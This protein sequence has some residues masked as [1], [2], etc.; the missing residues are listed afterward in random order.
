MFFFQGAIKIS[1]MILLLFKL[2][3]LLFFFLILICPPHCHR[4][5]QN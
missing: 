5:Y 1:I 3:C 4:N 2:F